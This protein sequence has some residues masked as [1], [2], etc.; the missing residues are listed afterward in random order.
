MWS[1]DNFK[2]CSNG[3]VKKQLQGNVQRHVGLRLQSIFV[4][5][6]K[7][8]LQVLNVLSIKRFQTQ[9]EVLDFLLKTLPFCLKMSDREQVG[10]IDRQVVRSVLEKVVA[11]RERRQCTAPL[12][13]AFKQEL[14]TRRQRKVTAGLGQVSKSWRN[15]TAGQSLGHLS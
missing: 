8:V 11:P 1:P 14:T 2:L 15:Q 6:I 13:N 7:Q 5:K 10:I 12:R 4:Q 9:K 3:V